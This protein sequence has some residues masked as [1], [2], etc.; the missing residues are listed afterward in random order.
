MLPFLNSQEATL[1]SAQGVTPVLAELLHVSVL[2]SIGCQHA[3]SV[4]ARHVAALAESASKHLDAAEEQMKAA[5]SPSTPRE[6]G[7]QAVGQEDLD[8]AST[9]LSG[10]P[11]EAGAASELPLE[12]ERVRRLAVARAAGAQARSKARE[13]ELVAKL[14]NKRK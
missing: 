4:T 6:G 10:I 9:V 12:V 5:R 8:N 3:L 11:S 14:T 2:Q 1:E 13:R 7:A